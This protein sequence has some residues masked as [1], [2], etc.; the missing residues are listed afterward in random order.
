MKRYLI[1]ILLK[2]M[3]RNKKDLHIDPSGVLFFFDNMQFVLDS[4]LIRA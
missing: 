1:E 4:F 2:G 3:I